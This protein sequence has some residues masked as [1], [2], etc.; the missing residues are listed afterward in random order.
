VNRTRRRSSSYGAFADTPLETILKRLGRDTVLLAG[1]L[2][3]DCVGTTARQASERGLLAVV[4][5][6]ACAT[7]SA[8]AHTEELRVLRRGFARVATV[9]AIIA[10]LDGRAATARA[11]MA[12]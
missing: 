5:R 6:D 9:D 8:R 11:A 4:A 12:R 7:D 10:E 2:T 1:T 3:N